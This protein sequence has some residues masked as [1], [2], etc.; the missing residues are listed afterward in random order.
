MKIAIHKRE[1]SYSDDWIEYC[2]K[3]N[4]EYKIV[5]CYDNDIM[6]QIKDC[7]ALFW[8]Y[9]H[10]IPQDILVAQQ[11]LFSAEAAGKYIFPDFHT[12]W[13]FDDKIGQKYLLEVAG[14]PFVPSYV[15]YS[16]TEALQW[17]EKSTFPKVFKLR[18][19][20][21]SHNVKLVKTKDKAVRLINK[22][23]GAGFRQYSALM[24]LKE[25][26]INYNLGV[27]KLIDLIKS[28]IRLGYKT[29]YERFISN[30]KGYAYF[31]DFI[32]E[33]DSDTRI[34]V[35][36]GK[37]V[38]FKRFVRKNDFRASGS[39]MRVFGKNEISEDAVKVAFETSKKLK[40]QCAAYDFIFHNGKPLIVEIS[41]GTTSATYRN[42]EGY[43]DESL[44]FYPGE[45][46]FCGW[47]VEKAINTK[48]NDNI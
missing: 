45:T 36:D 48:M 15:F 22:A 27:Y 26:Y 31:Q 4:C 30:E 24:G 9:H 29:D 42:C 16:K 21:G 20:A 1:T 40:L 32:P 5:N 8:H 7:D 35:V 12:M 13:H 33:N 41:F 2:E 28:F 10:A 34:V 43:W 6:M 14:V 37:A 39:R 18:S 25:A 19:G 23:F 38:G 44:N 3:N 17:V 11:V 46:D 47:I